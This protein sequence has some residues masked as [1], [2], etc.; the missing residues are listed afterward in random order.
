MSR[1]SRSFLVLALALFVLLSL[2]LFHPPESARTYLDPITGA[3]FGEGGVERDLDLYA[4]P[5]LRQPMDP[6]VRDAQT[7]ATRPAEERVEGSVMPALRNETA[8]KELGRATWRLMHT[9]TLRFP[10]KPTQDERKALND[11]FHLMGQLYPC[12][13][14]AAHF[15]KL[16]AA[17]PP[18]TSS[19]KAAS[20]WL[21]AVHNKVNI[22]LEKPEFD[23][24]YLGDT[25]DCG[26]GP[27]PGKPGEKKD[28]ASEED[29]EEANEVDGPVKGGRR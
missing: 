28:A 2:V 23:C 27:E 29:L 26:C 24:A 12:G 1:F 11:Y 13:D 9:M 6:I 4:Q 21:C 19:R 8:R 16:L 18:Q 7:V 5:D 25:Y 3:V 22:R 17:Y 14:C 20:N 10:E 15:R